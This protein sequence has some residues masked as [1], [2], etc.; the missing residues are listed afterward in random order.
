MVVRIRS[1]GN[2]R[3]LRL[4]SP[5]DGGVTPTSGPFP[6]VFAQTSLPTRD[7]QD[8]GSLVRIITVPRVKVRPLFECLTLF[9][10]TK[11]NL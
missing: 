8:N 10:P 4:E 11:S 6:L 3:Y 1:W 2:E 5:E 7:G 9:S